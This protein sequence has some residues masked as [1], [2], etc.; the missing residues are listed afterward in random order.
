MNSFM[1]W[2]QMSDRERLVWASAYSC[3][4][5]E[6]KQAARVADSAVLALSALNLDSKEFDSPEYEAARRY[7][8][9]RLDEFRAWYPVALA[10]WNRGQV[11]PSDVTEEAI[12]KAFETYRLCGT[13]VY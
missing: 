10:I 7:M 11:A 12:E 8:G 4:Q 13:D 6:P 3:H 5:G 9:L 2:H 1:P